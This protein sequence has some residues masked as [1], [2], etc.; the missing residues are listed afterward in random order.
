MLHQFQ[1][2]I[3]AKA[4]LSAEEVK[5]VQSLAVEKKLRKRQFLLQEGEVCRYKGF[6]CEG[7][8]RTYRTREDGSEHIM[9]FSPEDSW[10]IDADSYNTA[11]PSLFNIEALEDTVLLL[12]SREAI[13][14]LFAKIAAFKGYSESLIS[15]TLA[16]S[17][18]RVLMGISYTAEEKYEEFIN[19]F[20]EIFRRIPLHM[21]ASYLGVSRETL[22]RIR[23]AQAKRQL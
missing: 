19:T 9:R 3:N 12:W 18:Q 10:V 14:E 4:S 8:L 22:S 21:V 11:S 20:P 13:N 5:L 6:V 15:T 16:A 17:Q 7:L 1:D 23:N 2:H